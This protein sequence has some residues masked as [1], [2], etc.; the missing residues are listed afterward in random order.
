[1]ILRTAELEDGATL[2]AD[3]CIVGGGPAGISIACELIG[4]GLSVILLEAGQM[5]FA[6]SAQEGL[7]GE[8]E[9]GGAHSPPD[10]YRRRVLGGASSIWGGRCVP[11]DPI[12]LEPRNYVP[13]SGWPIAW[14]ELERFY[15][16][17]HGY[18]E[19][20]DFDYGVTSSL[21]P[22]AP[23]TIEGFRHPDILTDRLERFS[24]PTNFGKRFA[25]ALS[26]SPDIVLLLEA[27]ALRLILLEAEGAI[28]RVAHLEA[29][30]AGKRLNVRAGQYVL[31]AGGLE[32][33][34]LLML[35]DPSR[36]G[37]LGNEGGALGRYYMCHLENT[38]GRLQLTPKG[39][40]VSLHFERMPD[41]VYTRRKLAL[42]A[43]AQYREGLL[44]TAFRLH[45]P[46]ISDPSHHSGILSAVYL[47]KDS[48][49]PEY[50]RKLATIEISKRDSLPRD[51]AFWLAHGVNVLRDAPAV[52]RF[53][54]DWTRRRV[55]PRRKL[56]FVVVGS[57]AGIYPLDVNAEQIP[58]PDSRVQLGERTDRHGRPLVKV[59]WRMASQDT[60]SLTRA[61][62]L[63]QRAFAVSGVA[64]LDF[65][66]GLEDSVAGSTPVGGHHIGT[67]R[68]AESPRDGVVDPNGAVH[69]VANLFC[70][71]SAVF[72]TCGHA[73]P[74]LTLIAL[75]VRL[76]D[77]LKGR[78]GKSGTRVLV[79]Q[80][81][82]AG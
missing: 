66:H 2:H 59:A 80:T 27:E 64:R 12:D 38:I 69:G 15:R 62:R 8:V 40:P 19:A 13:Y 48:V 44:N 20:G 68:M 39:R 23:D 81:E 5:S 58:N 73:N 32:I 67:A 51:A 35:S 52:G 24:P 7:S 25:R 76:A 49:L 45:H 16:R 56:P 78:F 22:E 26:E 75:A 82:A 74:T 31:A 3:L 41:G 46:P 28:T 54:I 21:G 43:E 9:P 50:R 79:K 17:A 6:K 36:R 77:H 65:E 37:G 57:R 10:M 11:L 60:D 70:A 30:A 72:P 42:S 29:V 53:C 1:V 18:F 71:G 55:L 34:R 33:P 61:L 4:S 14:P 63:L 47:L